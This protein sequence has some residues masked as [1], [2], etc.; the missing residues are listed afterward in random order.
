MYQTINTISPIKYLFMIKFTTLLLT[1]ALIFGRSLGLRDIIFQLQTIFLLI[2]H[3]QM[4]FLFPLGCALDLFLS[5]LDLLDA[6]LLASHL[7][8]CP[9][10]IRW[11]TM[12]LTWLHCI[13]HSSHYWQTCHG[14]WQPYQEATGIRVTIISCFIPKERKGTRPLKV[15][16]TWYFSMLASCQ[17]PSQKWVLHKH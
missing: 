16:Y 14:I 9:L 8:S 7:T 13:T 12:I 2:P 11:Y 1:S 10:T 5:A 17:L 4:Y 15:W 6:T 3:G